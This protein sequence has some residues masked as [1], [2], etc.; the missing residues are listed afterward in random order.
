MGNSSYKISYHI[1]GKQDFEIKVWT[2]KNGE[3][4]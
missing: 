2:D 3:A 4:L 1:T